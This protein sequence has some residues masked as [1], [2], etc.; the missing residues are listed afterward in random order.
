MGTLG[1]AWKAALLVYLLTTRSSPAAQ[2]A[3]SQVDWRDDA[4]GYNAF[5][6]EWGLAHVTLSP[7]DLGSF[8]AVPGG[9]LTYINITT[10]V[11]TASPDAWSVQNRPA[12]VRSTAPE[13]FSPTYDLQFDL[14]IVRGSSRV[15][16]LDYRFA[17][18][19]TA[20][21]VPPAASTAN[22]S[23]GVQP[24][25][26]GGI[27]YSDSG[28]GTG[29]TGVS[30]PPAP[31]QFPPINPGGDHE[32]HG[33][34]SDRTKIPAVNEP[35]NHCAPGALT[36]SIEYLD[37]TS[38]TF[39]LPDSTDFVLAGLST[40][41]GTTFSSGTKN[42]NILPGKASY[43]SSKGI[44]V[45]TFVTKDVSVV[46]D[47]L[48]AGADVE[49]LISWGST[50]AGRKLGGH[51]AMVTELLGGFD[52]NGQLQNYYM[53]TV[54]DP[55]QGD[56]MAQNSYRDYEVNFNHSIA[57]YYIGTRVDGFVVE[58]V[59]EPAMLSCFLALVLVRRQRAAAN[60][61]ALTAA[62]DWKR[63]RFPG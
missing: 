35:H 47:A 46:I 43:A 14:G 11:P 2:V 56:G 49:A 61:I 44:P 33:G 20:L 37:N 30:A 40:S 57:G 27:D 7:A 19:P 26:F 23:V 55:N 31:P 48:N 24:F 52:A 22:S 38:D 29:G 50:A 58:V 16:A 53:R 59:P 25:L 18:S 3:F 63:I 5:Q 41:L 15:S 54:D 4:G 36:R 9:Y 42:A 34:V 10:T 21:L 1:Y 28:G 60:R 45:T 51:M 8:T 39:D 17:L 13:A 62:R 6:S 32:K 12:F